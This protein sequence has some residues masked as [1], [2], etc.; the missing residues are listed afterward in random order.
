VTTPVWIITE[1]D[2]SEHRP[3]LIAWAE[4]NG[5]DPTRIDPHGLTIEQSNDGQAIQFTEYQVHE[6]GTKV[7]DLTTPQRY[8]TTQ[9]TAP[10]RH[11]LPEGI[12]QALCT[13]TLG[14]Q[15]PACVTERATG[16]YGW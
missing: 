2:I 6:D 10:L 3:A 11:A 9:R 12:G 15:C 1:Q 5:L 4:A 16:R 14:E 7:L 8:A 13:C